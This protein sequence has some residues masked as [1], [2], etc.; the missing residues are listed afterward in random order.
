[1]QNQNI[2]PVILSGGSGTRL[3]PLSRK[4]KPKQFLDL[5]DDGNTIFGSTLDRINS[6]QYSEP[7]II[8]NKDHKYLV[9][10][11]LFQKN[12]NGSI[13]LEPASRNTAA[14]LALAALYNI[15]KNRDDVLL[16][17][18]SDH[19][20]KDISKFNQYIKNAVK[21]VEKKYIITFGIKPTSPETGYGY[22]KSS[23]T[24][25]DNDIFKVNE[26]TEKPNKK[27]ALTFL[28]L[29][30]YFWNSGIFLAKAS[31]FL[32]SIKV[33]HPNILKYCQQALGKGSQDKD[34]VSLDL[35][36]FEKLPDISIDYAIAE[37][38]NNLA[39]CPMDI[40]WSDL[41]GW[42]SLYK[43]LPKDS[44]NNYLKG[45][46]ITEDCNNCYINSFDNL[47]VGIG[48]NNLVITSIKDAILISDINSDQ[49]VK[50]IVT[51]LKENNRTEHLLHVKV[52]RPWGY[53][54]ELT[55]S[56]NFKV[57][58]IV[59]NPKSA[60]SLQMHNYRSEHWIVVKGVA[61]V[62]CGDREF[63]LEENQSTY[64]SKQQKHRL[65]NKED[66]A[67]E[68]I[69]IQTGSYL[70]E[71]DIIRFSDIYNREK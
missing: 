43:N 62:I 45:D 70:G 2:V 21:V 56:A 67:L 19:L 37:K 27:T 13:I 29:G 5:M 54:E 8:C 32:E 17:I 24:R 58:K 14:S 55:L 46:I 64:I 23:N 20:I 11:E 36:S 28:E 10:Q 16:V 6:H 50:N 71:D 25:I 65:T 61:H 4:S 59:V 44:D 26:F 35:K 41:G 12:I 53:Y 66:T 31:V 42:K 69:E 52:E 22:I 18:P 48:L 33:Y 68:L 39:L 47:V 1:M 57:K 9:S 15:A 34:F 30:D 49:R 63:I 38:S 3:W 60:L 7:I 40:E 51:K